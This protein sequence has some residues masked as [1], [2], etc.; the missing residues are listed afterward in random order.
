MPKFSVRQD[1]NMFV[2]PFIFQNIAHLHKECMVYY[3]NWTCGKINI[4]LKS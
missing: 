1:A 3:E 2:T 4:K